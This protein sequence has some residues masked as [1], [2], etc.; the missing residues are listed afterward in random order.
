M[1]SMAL[2]SLP[3]EILEEIFVRAYDP[4]NQLHALGCVCKSISGFTQSDGI[5]KQIIM[6]YYSWASST[7]TSKC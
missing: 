5:W 1:L 4:A 2:S 6:R 7:L 3:N